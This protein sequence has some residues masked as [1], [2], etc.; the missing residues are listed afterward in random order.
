MPDSSTSEAES[1]FVCE[2]EEWMRSACAGE[3]FY[4]ERE[5]KRYCVLHFP[6]LEKSA[7]FSV[8][9]RRKLENNDFK[10][11]GVWFPD[12][13]SFGGSTSAPRRPSTR[14]LSAQSQTSAVHSSPPLRSSPTQCSRI[15]LSTTAQ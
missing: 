5:G 8:A 14:P 2:C 10:F 13:V 4:E 11:W 12:P 6:G 15:R 3:A 7:D 1:D 9:L